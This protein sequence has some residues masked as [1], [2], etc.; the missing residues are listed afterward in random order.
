MESAGEATRGQEEGDRQRCGL[1]EMAN[2]GR[3]SILM[4]WTTKTDLL[5]LKSCERLAEMILVTSLVLLKRRPADGPL[6]SPQ[7]R[8]WKRTGMHSR[9]MVYSC[10]RLFLDSVCL[11]VQKKCKRHTWPLKVRAHP[12]GP[13]QH[14]Y[15]NN[16]AVTITP[17]VPSARSLLP[18]LISKISQCT[19]PFPP[20][21]YP[22]ST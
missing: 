14:F 12:V 2:H 8:C 5:M 20:P 6:L 15:T 9:C 11:R 4:D 16:L 18:W 19:I 13:S 21:L 7:Q 10:L 22:F 3:R 1:Q 17:A